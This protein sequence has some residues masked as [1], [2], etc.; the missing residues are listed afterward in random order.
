M[1]SRAPLPDSEAAEFAVRKDDA[2]GCDLHLLFDQTTVH[3]VESLDGQ[4]TPVS[5]NLCPELRAPRLIAQPAAADLFRTVVL[6]AA[7]LCSKGGVSVLADGIPTEV[8]VAAGVT[9]DPATPI[10]HPVLRIAAATARDGE[11]ELTVRIAG[12][13][14]TLSLIIPAPLAPPSVLLVERDDA[15]RIEIHAALAAAGFTV[16]SAT[17]PEAVL[18]LLASGP[19]AAVLVDLHEDGSDALAVARTARGAHPG[20][21]VFALAPETP[22]ACRRVLDQAGFAGLLRKPFSAERLRALIGR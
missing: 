2:R 17:G 4:N 10:H 7:A 20:T 19:Y 12:D 13:R 1:A 18:R 15:Q 9:I 21:A 11:A 22:A 8:S 5:L 16:E 14:L 3:I 6:A